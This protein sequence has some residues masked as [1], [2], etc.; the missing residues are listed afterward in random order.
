M[1]KAFNYNKLI[2]FIILIF[3]YY[4]NDNDIYKIKI[5]KIRKLFNKYNSLFQKDNNITALFSYY[6]SLINKYSNEH[7]TDYKT[8]PLI[9]II[10]PLYNN[11]NEYILRLLMS[12]EEQTFKN[13]R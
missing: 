7:D 4:E 11:K 6:R 9:S 10:I 1:P 3:I 12:I 5:L 2:L 8:N 13:I